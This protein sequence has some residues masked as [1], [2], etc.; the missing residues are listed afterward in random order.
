MKKLVTFVAA[1]F[2]LM[3]T[4]AFAEGYFS[5]EDQESITI[6]EDL[7]LEDGFVL[8]ATAEKWMNFSKKPVHKTE[9]G[10]EFNKALQL[11]GSGNLKVRSVSFPAKAGETI[12]IYGNSTSKTDVRAIVVC[13]P[14]GKPFAELPMDIDGQAGTI[15]SEGKVVAPADGTYTIYSKKSGIN[16][17]YIGVGN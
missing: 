1:A 12:T 4:C 16:V 8:H 15:A 6:T 13:G 11:Q 3:G 14:D 7:E 5:A 17:Y 2:M 9:S 10:E